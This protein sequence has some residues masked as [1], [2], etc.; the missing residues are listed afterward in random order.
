LIAVIVVVALFNIGTIK[1]WFVDFLDWLQLNP[2]KGFILFM[3]LYI[4]ATIFFIPGLIL[5]MGSGFAFSQATNNIF[6]GTLIG[7]ISS[8]T[9]AS[10]G[11]Q[12]AFL[13]SRYILRD[14]FQKLGRKNIKFQAI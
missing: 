4:I 10:I 1:Q 9:G 11:A 13:I 7:T 12:I 6:L 2:K 8:W 3:G 14:S 5:T